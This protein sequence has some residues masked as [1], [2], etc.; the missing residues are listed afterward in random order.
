MKIQI[1]PK[2]AIRAALVFLSLPA[3]A[4]AHAAIVIQNAWARPTPPGAPTAVGYLTIVN[5]SAQPDRLIRA[6]SPAAKTLGLHSLSNTGGVM[7]MRTVPE[8]LPIA[9]RSTVVLDP[10]GYHLM[11]EGLHAPFKLGDQAPAVLHF[12]HAGA[13][14]VR[15]TVS[16]GPDSM[17]GMDMH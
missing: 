1:G 15:F 9:P 17:P 16:S 4:S 6:E 3:A 2:R 14:R 11:F 12:Q 5:R 10:N 8:G 13:I 7:R